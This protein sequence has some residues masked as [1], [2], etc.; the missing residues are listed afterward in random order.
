MIG[1]KSIFPDF[2]NGQFHQKTFE[3][4][5][6]NRINNIPMK[7]QNSYLEVDLKHNPGKTSKYYGNIKHYKID[8]KRILTKNI[9]EIMN[10]DNSLQT[11][12]GSF[13][14]I[15]GVDLETFNFIT[16]ET[17]FNKKI[18]TVLKSLNLKQNYI[19]PEYYSARQN[20]NIFLKRN[21]SS[22]NF[23]NDSSGR[24]A[25]NETELENSSFLDKNLLHN[26]YHIK[27]SPITEN[28]LV[29]YEKAI[30][31]EIEMIGKQEQFKQKLI[32]MSLPNLNIQDRNLEI[33]T[34]CKK[35]D[36]TDLIKKDKFFKVNEKDLQVNYYGTGNVVRYSSR[37]L[38]EKHHRN[39]KIAMSSERSL[40]SE[41]K[42]KSSSMKNPVFTDRK[43]KLTDSK[44]ELIENYKN[45]LSKS[46]MQST[47]GDDNSLQFTTERKSSR[48]N[49]KIQIL[50]EK[51]K[52]TNLK[53]FKTLPKNYTI[54]TGSTN[55]NR[56]LSIKSQPNIRKIVQANEKKYKCN[57]PPKDMAFNG[58]SFNDY[59]RMK[60]KKKRTKFYRSNSGEF[61]KS[62]KTL[63]ERAKSPISVRSLD[64]SIDSD[65]A[66][67]IWMPIL[68]WPSR[69]MEKNIP[70]KYFDWLDK[71]NDG[72][73]VQKNMQDDNADGDNVI[74][75]LSGL[76]GNSEKNIV[77]LKKIEGEIFIINFQMI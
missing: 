20:N 37:K 24:F 31:E 36:I 76:L 2:I 68:N 63:K 6:K 71:E 65:K 33:K 1:N 57:I 77:S 64:L 34:P 58:K 16:K 60:F 30:K 44:R 73:L 26:K 45:F 3:D 35:V 51:L 48:K 9:S 46:I 53:V 74:E 22:R 18:P 38:S 67:E 29:I 19:L 27:L 13:R 14:E 42:N 4:I 62:I 23:T 55:R 66:K 10:T 41:A 54:P 11:R 21:K 15:D 61:L 59:Y 70:D 8:N 39:S 7:K 5:E 43:F 72:K 47:M 56:Y 25:T 17:S 69:L 32:N 49:Y 12:S 50:K 52:P 40:L 75:N 28:E